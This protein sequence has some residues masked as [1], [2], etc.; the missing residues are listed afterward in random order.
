MKPVAACIISPGAV[1]KI[2]MAGAGFKLM[3]KLQGA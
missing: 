2:N 3:E 1:N